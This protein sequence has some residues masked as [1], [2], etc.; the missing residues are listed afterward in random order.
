[1]ADIDKSL[2]NVR[3][4]ITIPSEQEQTDVVVEMQE[5]APSPDNTEITENP[6]GSVEVDFDPGAA[7]PSQSNE[8]YSNLAELLPDSIL[9]PLGSELYG[10]FTDYKESRR[11]WERS[12]SKGLDLLGFQFEQRTQP[13]QGASGATHPVLAEAVTQFQ[14]QAYKE[15]L[16]ADGPIRTQILGA[17]TPEKEAQSQRVKDFM[18]YQIM[19]VMR[20]YEPE[21]DQM[22]FYLPLAGSAFKKV[23]YDDLLGRAVSKFVPA[24]DLI[25][26]YSATSLEDA[27]A[28]CHTV[29]ISEND[30]RKQQVGGFYRDVEIF[31]PY[32]E[33]TEVKKKERELEG[34]Q[35][36]G[37][38]KNDKMYTLVEFH[39]D[40]DLEGFED[41]SPDGMPTGIK[42]PYIVTVDSS[43]RKILSIRRNFKVDDPKKLK[44]QYFVHFK[45]LPG[46]GFYGFGLIHMIG[47]LTRA[48]TAALRQLIDA[49]TLSNLPAG[50]KMR[51]IRVNNDAQSL[52]PG[53]FRDVDAPG[54]NL[55]DAFMTLPY[56]EPSQTLL[57]LMG[58]CVQA[59]QR[60]A[61]IADMQVGDGNQQAAVGTTV[62]LLERGSRVMSAIHKRLYSSMKN[63]F[64]L[65]SDVFS[66]YL[67]PV[68]PYEVVG[69]DKQIKQADFDDRID[70]LP[71]ADPN[72]FSSTQRVSIAQTELQLAQSNPEMHNM[73]EAYR[74]MYTAIGVKNI[75]TILPPPEETVPKNP[76]MEHIDALGGKEFEAFTGQD[77]QAHISAHLAFMST[78][79]AQNNPMIMASLEKNIF[80]HI[81]L[82]SDEQVQMEM[83]EKIMQVQQLQ[84]TMQNPE[85]QQNPE[86]KQE[87]D[88]LVMEIE[89]RKAV[90]ISEMMEEY[91]KEQNKLTGDFGNDPIAKL[92]AR[93]LDL[94]AQDNIRKE[95]EDAAR[96]NLDK[97]KA[98]MNQS[99]QQEKMDQTEDLAELRAETS[100]TKQKMS[101]QAKAKADATKRFDVST[102]KGPRR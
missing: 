82:M 41:R 38:Q 9:Q 68:Y 100:I 76:A 7:A 20:E 33:E 61:S 12:Y 62:A 55:K 69:A 25:V 1:M 65:L 23:Y 14:A 46:L 85:V 48:A 11:E 93:E 95:K 50:F 88:R 64:N 72:I 52:Q 31:A 15:L 6:D 67:P 97:M 70:I 94:K 37:Q 60:F 32:A 98:M 84:E 58:I 40:L 16:P 92:R 101:N 19:N 21:F 78:N 75:D 34:I 35:M 24:D 51:G 102:L 43:S 96:I 30:L 29:K 90:L 77:H 54:G 5:T 80:E 86:L 8:H 83:Q 44:I 3:Q 87:M 66:T 18:N 28:I 79:M 4:N 53:E 81:S 74:D 26:P 56:K 49:G 10:N 89:S 57:S 13:F 91:V 2:P 22:L 42:V 39:V 27:E 45:F 73:Y 17:A 71:V 36:N 63:E 47:G 99:Y 59:G